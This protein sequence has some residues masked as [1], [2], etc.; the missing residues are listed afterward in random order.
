MPGHKILCVAEKPAIAK[1]VSQ[2]LAGGQVNTRSIRGNQYV[3]NYEFT[4]SFPG[5]GNCQVVMTSLLGHLTDLDF[6]DRY[7]SWKSCPPGQ[8]F[9]VPIH[10]KIAKVSVT[11]L[12]RTSADLCRINKG[13][14]TI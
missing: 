4:Y 3:K 9:D 10:I 11:F 5:W 2:H 7:R 13:L 6:D 1:A 8:L 14:Q 12:R